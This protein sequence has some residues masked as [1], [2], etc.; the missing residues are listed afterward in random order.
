MKNCLNE[1]LTSEC[2]AC[3]YWWDGT[4]DKNGNVSV[5]CGAPFPIDHCEAFASMMKQE[6]EIQ[7][8]GE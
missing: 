1:Y 2:A 8:E 6:Q 3:P 4:P 7:M 5:G